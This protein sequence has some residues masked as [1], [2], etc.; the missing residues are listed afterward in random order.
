VSKALHITRH[1]H[2]HRG[3]SWYARIATSASCYTFATIHLEHKNDKISYTTL[4]E[5]LVVE[6]IN[7]LIPKEVTLPFGSIP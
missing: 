3:W 5:W 7:P 6:R 4:V 2:S 1:Y